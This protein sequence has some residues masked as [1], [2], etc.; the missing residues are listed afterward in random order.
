MNNKMPFIK[1]TAPPPPPPKPKPHVRIVRT[2]IQFTED[3]LKHLTEVAEKLKNATHVHLWH[4]PETS[5]I[6]ITPAPAD[7]PDA[8]LV[9]NG[10]IHAKAFW[11]F[12]NIPTPVKEHSKSL[13]PHEEGVK[14]AI[15]AGT[16]G[17][18]KRTTSSAT[19]APNS[20]GAKWKNPAIQF[21]ERE[22]K[23]RR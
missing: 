21:Q 1:Y 10:K 8:F 12:A 11:E 19:T 7:D 20:V 13:E 5:Q 6:A 3:G 23:A 2:I 22:D 4:D 15:G 14:L 17:K 18:R 16:S 9:N